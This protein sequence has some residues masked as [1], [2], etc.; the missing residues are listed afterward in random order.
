M[1]SNLLICHFQS[2]KHRFFS[3]LSQF[4]STKQIMKP[5]KSKRKPRKSF[6]YEDGCGDENSSTLTDGTS[7]E[8]KE[9]EIF[10]APRSKDV[11]HGAIR[12][13]RQRSK[14]VTTS[15]FSFYLIC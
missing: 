10:L 3:N 6:I 11:D 5:G 12:R 7:E 9:G 2:E 14:K 13:K 4:D 1:P 8:R 15:L